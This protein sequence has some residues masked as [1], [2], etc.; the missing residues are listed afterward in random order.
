[1]KI[2]RWKVIDSLLQS[3]LELAP[4]DR[5]QFLSQ[6]CIEDASL[7]DE[8]ISL[9]TSYR[10]AGEFLETPALE[11]AARELSLEADA[12]PTAPLAGQIISHY[13]ILKMIGSGGM[14]TVWLAERC[15]GRFER[16]VAIKFIH[17]AL[18][19]GSAAAR[20]KRE[21]AILGRLA[22][23]SIAELIDAGLTSIG[24]PFL[25]LELVEGRAIDDYCDRNR[26]G[27]EPRILLFLDVLAAVSH[28]H[29]NLIVHRDIKPSNVLVRNDGQVKL[30]DFGIAKAIEDGTEA[31]AA[32][33]LN[34]QTG[35]ALTPLFAAPEQVTEGPITTATDIYT[36]G[37]LLYLLLTGQ[38]PAGPG[39]HS[40]AHLI[41]TIV[42]QEP[43]RPS[44]AVF[45]ISPEGAA[46]RS[47]TPQKLRRQLRGDLDT[48]VSKA[49]K[50]IPSERYTSVLAFADDLRRHLEH[51]PV[52]ARPDSL[53]YRTSRFV[54]RNFA[55]VAVGAVA[56][57]AIVAGVSAIVIQGRM[58]QKERDFAFRQLARVHQHDDFL[59]F[60]LS[61]AAPMGKPFTVNTLL[62]RAE[63]IVEKQKDSTGKLDLME[64]IGS[65]Y[66]VQDLHGMAK[67]ILERAYAISRQSSDPSVR[68]AG[69]CSLAAEL[70]RDEDLDR[71]EALIEEGL[72]ALPN[73]QQYVLDRVVC[74]RDGSEVA[75]QRGAVT[76]AVNRMETAKRT[77][78]GSP[79]DS[80]DLEST[81]SLDLASMYS[82]A[83]RDQDA[84]D[85]FQR[86]AALM[87]KTGRDE[88]QTAMVLYSGL[89][90]ELDQVGR[91]LEAE[92]WDR[93]AIDI[94]RDGA[95]EDAVPAMVLNNYGRVLRQLNRLPEA[96][97][98]VERAHKKAVQTQDE[99]VVN[100]SL[101][102]LA[103]IYRLQHNLRR[104]ETVLNEVEPRLAKMLP[105]GHYAFSAVPTERGL[106]AL[107]KKDSAAA[108][109]F[110]NQ[111]IATLEATVNHGGN[112]SFALP[113]VYLNR[114]MIYLAMQRPDLAEADASHARALL[115]SKEHV[116]GNTSKLGSA[117]LAEARALAA[118]GRMT[119]ARTAASQALVQ[120]EGS[121]GAD[122]PDALAA[123]RLTQ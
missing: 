80:D 79:F 16:K 40:P 28:A 106:I 105:P 74:L 33:P 41:K 8:I 7:K 117:N 110:M 61:D 65:D 20:F 72:T 66:G 4:G 17:L 39:P 75:R 34:T 83:G 82:E 84:L 99:L 71:A 12:L 18:L 49:M 14:G 15:D 23:P 107:E 50:K 38:H 19:D 81:I 115:E 36:L 52:A 113:G 27:V 11:V 87:T 85:E 24:E 95:N 22:H 94:S 93:K 6:A 96:A 48:I 32:T 118:E 31:G 100:Q 69:S 10:K 122:H 35:A 63:H 9:L 120:F 91:P 5:E 56:L 102:E 30:L 86:A 57:L 88:T 1:M 47:A 123:R 26:L 54:R 116:H 60:L 114:S 104:A 109:Q 46:N 97:D 53:G 59:E 55:M 73:D 78:S 2:E 51:K 25:V 67:P 98:H 45:L 29:S 90:L 108:L 103:R 64:W 42:D 92:K 43:P 44:D 121:I 101:L 62:E 13:R 77:M 68:A 3:A 111:A 76:V 21:G 119:E 70:A 58:A 89:A 112:G 37:V